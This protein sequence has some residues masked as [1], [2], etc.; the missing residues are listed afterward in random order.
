MNPMRK[1]AKLRR[2]DVDY[3][4]HHSLL[5]DSVIIE[6]MSKM[7]AVFPP[8][9]LEIDRDVAKPI[10][11]VLAERLVEVGF[12]ENYEPNE[13]GRFLEDLIDR[14]FVP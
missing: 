13:E 11:D 8:A 14:L 1:T 12:D 3:L 6:L 7:H 5:P 4:R 10:R 2:S 9:S